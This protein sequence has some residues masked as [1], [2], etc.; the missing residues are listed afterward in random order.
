MC[1][2]S[3]SNIYPTNK[4]L[5]IKFNSENSVS[6]ITI[7]NIF[8]LEGVSTYKSCYVF[9][10][11]CI[12]Y[13]YRLSA[14]INGGFISDNQTLLNNMK[15]TDSS[16]YSLIENYS[17]NIYFI[18]CTPS[19]ALISNISNYTIK[20]NADANQHL[21]FALYKIKSGT[22]YSIFK[23]YNIESTIVT[24]Y[25]HTHYNTQLLGAITPKPEF[26]YHLLN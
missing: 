1:E 15:Y 16:I 14:I 7:V 24:Y 2:K 19:I 22:S 25:G 6:T 20:Y 9:I 4:S 21:L 3:G 12:N 17:D 5:Y 8:F 11:N 26:S 23:T 10:C 13:N 18:K